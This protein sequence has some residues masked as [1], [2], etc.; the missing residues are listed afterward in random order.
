[1]KRTTTL[2]S[3]LLLLTFFATSASAQRFGGIKIESN[4]PVDVYIDGE[5]ISD[6]VQSCMIANLRRGTY[7]IEVFGQIGNGRYDSS[8][9]LFAERV[10]YSGEGVREIL[11]N[12][13]DDYDDYYPDEYG[14]DFRRPMDE[15]TFNEFFTKLK[16]CSF[17]SERKS[18]I[19]LVVPHSLFYTEQVRKVAEL[20]TFDS[21]KMWL[22][23]TMLPYTVDRGRVFILMDMLD[24]PSSKEELSQFVNGLK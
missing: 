5:R 22:F 18:M 2:F 6:R 8:E 7:L 24:F 9:P 12:A 10:F 17:D 19:D 14:G 23:K 11:V 21:E 3:L 13:E 1:M 15:R 20:Y 4:I 16:A